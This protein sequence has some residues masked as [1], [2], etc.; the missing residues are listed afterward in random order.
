L[1]IQVSRVLV[2]HVGQDVLSVLQT[3]HHLEV[4]RLHGRIQRVGASLSALVDVGDDLSLRAEHDFGV[5]LEVDLH[6]LVG[7][8]K[9]DSMSSAHPLLDIDYVGDLPALLGEVLRNLL[10]G[11]GLLGSL[12]VASEML[13]KSH[14]LL[15]V[16]G[17]FGQ[18]VLFADVLAIGTATLHVVKVEAVGVK[19]DLGGV[20]EEHTGCFVAQVV[21]EAVLGGVIDPFLNP[22]FILAVGRHSSQSLGR[23]GSILRC[24]V[25]VCCH[26]VRLAARDHLGVADGG[27]GAESTTWQGWVRTVLV[28]IA[29]VGGQELTDVRRGGGTGERGGW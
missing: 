9:H 21:P 22:H 16:S 12:E 27:R 13:E 25:S 5:V 3:L 19:N 17:V 20:V 24:C 23:P 14:L 29:V 6:H 11:L 2:Q 15:Q 1:S 26:G 8:S 18:S 4:S 28:V 10:V 7:K